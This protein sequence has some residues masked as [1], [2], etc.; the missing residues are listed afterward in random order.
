M[1]PVLGYLPRTPFRRSDP[2]SRYR[3]GRV[4]Q[5]KTPHSRSGR[6]IRTSAAVSVAAAVG[7]DEL[8]AGGRVIED[9]DGVLVD[10]GE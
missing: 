10:G 1:L 7:Q 8:G 2:L 6:A 3:E 9:V 4:D 5:K